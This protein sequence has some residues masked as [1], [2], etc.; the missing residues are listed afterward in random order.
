ML[1]NEHVWRIDDIGDTDIYWRE[2]E[3]RWI[4]CIQPSEKD[5]H[6]KEERAERESWAIYMRP[7]RPSDHPIQHESKFWTWSGYTVIRRF[8][9]CRFCQFKARTILLH[10]FSVTAGGFR[11]SVNTRISF[12]MSITSPTWSDK[13]ARSC[14]GLVSS[15]PTSNGKMEDFHSTAFCF[16]VARIVND[17]SMTEATTEA[18]GTAIHPQRTWIYVSTL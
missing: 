3:M 8:L 7:R 4:N 17:N 13:K 10:Y 6:K 9:S 14:S 2:N 12:D 15:F 18:I 5:G 11:L 16:L 1:A